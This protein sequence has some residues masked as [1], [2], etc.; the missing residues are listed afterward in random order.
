MPKP[1]IMV[2]GIFFIKCIKK[3][4]ELEEFQK[5]IKKVLTND[6]VDCIINKSVDETGS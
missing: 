3:M 1:Q 5:K 2:C 6:G 4:E